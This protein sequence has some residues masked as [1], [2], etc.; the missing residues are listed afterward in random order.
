VL[1]GL[2]VRGRSPNALGRSAAAA[3]HEM[4]AANALVSKDALPPQIAPFPMR[5]VP[6]ST[7]SVTAFDPAHNGVTRCARIIFTP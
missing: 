6:G 5:V 4:L 2:S 3:V 1:D 7:V